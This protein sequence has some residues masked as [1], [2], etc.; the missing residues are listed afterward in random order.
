MS[1]R[2]LNRN[3]PSRVRDVGHKRFEQVPQPL[4][5]H[6]LRPTRRGDSSYA[7]AGVTRD[8]VGT[9]LPDCDVLVFEQQ[10]NILLDKT[11]S[12]GS[13]N[14]SVKVPNDTN[15]YYVVSFL[16]GAPDVHGVTDRD[17]RG[18]LVP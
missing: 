15:L 12:D 1:R 6:Q 3:P 10:T 11:R 2:S 14:Y 9:A 16:E 13:G 5:R 4:M 7:I 18:T 17:V 8:S